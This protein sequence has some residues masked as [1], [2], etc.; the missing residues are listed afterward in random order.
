M[1]S[2]V[3]IT[4][5]Q[6]VRNFEG[7]TMT[8]EQEL[9]DPTFRK[10]V[11]SCKTKFITKNVRDEVAPGKILSY[12]RHMVLLIPQESDQRT[13][14][15][16]A[17]MPETIEERSELM[18]E[19]GTPVFRPVRLSLHRGSDGVCDR[20]YMIVM[21]KG[22]EETLLKFP[23]GTTVRADTVPANMEEQM[24]YGSDSSEGNY[25]VVPS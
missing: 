19:V 3:T 11:L 2:V 15:L 18:A 24:G 12:V 8:V 10:Y 5:V 13:L 17:W 16:M 23:E 1:G 21:S 14:F 20:P 7:A 22:D 6:V 25:D 4:F 9:N